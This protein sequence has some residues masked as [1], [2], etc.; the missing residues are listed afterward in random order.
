LLVYFS[1]FFISFYRRQA[2]GASAARPR[3]G[4]TCRPANALPLRY[5]LLKAA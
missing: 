2:G 3:A 1:F 4:P 5:A